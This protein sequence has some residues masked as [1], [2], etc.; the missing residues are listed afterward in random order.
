MC[1][2]IGTGVLTGTLLYACDT[3]GRRPAPSE[4]P[5]ERRPP[6][7]VSVEACSLVT[8]EEAEAVIGSL[9]SEPSRY[10]D[11]DKSMCTYVTAESDTTVAVDHWLGSTPASSSEFAR[12]LVEPGMPG[13][14][15]RG[16]VQPVE[17]IGAPAAWYDVGGPNGTVWLDV[18]RRSAT[19][20]YR[21]RLES[22][23]L[24]AASALAQSAS[25]RL[26]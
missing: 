20:N 3:D 16:V 8:R 10:R 7:G 17:G 12:M 6:T 5:V 21:L 13:A 19:G 22:S 11:A 24:S 15:L 9:V 1:R 4:Q 26:P 2:L 23:S 18:F 25:A 14:A